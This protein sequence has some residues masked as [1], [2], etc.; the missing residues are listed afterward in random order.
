M[1]PA[2]LTHVE[3]MAE[4]T[5]LREAMASGV[6]A[7]DLGALVEFDSAALAVLLAA[8]RASSEAGLPRFI[9]VPDKLSRL[10]SLYGVEALVFAHP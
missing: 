8:R 4:L 7:I 10:A 3:A 6:R 5:R 9:N 2:R 1:I